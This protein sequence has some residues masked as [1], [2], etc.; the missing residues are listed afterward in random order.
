MNTLVQKS[1]AFLGRGR[2]PGFQRR[3]GRKRGLTQYSSGTRAETKGRFDDGRRK[4]GFTSRK[5]LEKEGGTGK[6]KA[7]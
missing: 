7:L 3:T 2:G 5:R 4:T 6:A 1:K